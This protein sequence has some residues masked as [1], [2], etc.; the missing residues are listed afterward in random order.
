MFISVLQQSGHFFPVLKRIYI[1]KKSAITAIL[2][3]DIDIFSTFFCAK[4]KLAQISLF[5]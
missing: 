4:N 2:S 3:S 1:Y 5:V